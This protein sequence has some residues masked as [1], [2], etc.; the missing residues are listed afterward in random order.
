MTPDLQAS[1]S[2]ASRTTPVASVAD[3]GFAND[4]DQA[5][6]R[7]NLRLT[8]GLLALWFG[9]TF[10]CVFWAGELNF[11]LFGW[12]FSFWM[13]AQGA[14]LV[15]CAIVWAYAWIMGRRDAEFQQASKAREGRTRP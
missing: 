9:L 4:A 8:A 7:G 10:G 1:D 11:S 2:A 12:P 15:Y 6:W 3:S 14:L 13:A 5:Y